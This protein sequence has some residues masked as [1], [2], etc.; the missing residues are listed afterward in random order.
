MTPAYINCVKGK[1]REL[2]D[3]GELI[4]ALLNPT[5]ASIRNECLR[6]LPT[7]T[8]KM[9]KKILADFFGHDEKKETLNETISRVDLEDLKA[10]KNFFYGE[11]SKPNYKV[12]EMMAW[13]IDFQPRP[14]TP[15]IDYATLSAGDANNKKENEKSTIVSAGSSTSLGKGLPERQKRT[16]KWKTIAIASATI[17]LLGRGGYQL[18]DKGKTEKQEAG[19]SCMYWAENHYE[20]GACI[21]R[22]G[23]SVLAPFDELRF[24]NFRRI[25]DTSMITSNLIGKLWYRIKEGKFEFYTMEGKHPVD[26]RTLRRLTAKSYD[27]YLKS[28]GDKTARQPW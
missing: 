21:Q 13:L 19:D 15:S 22:G 20:R 8:G 2:R 4:Q 12:V 18:F 17:L 11:T 24:R 5:P 9:D 3:S 1:L 27:N 26:R 10:L 16:S 28:L 6:L 25:T 14:Y 7:R 23:D